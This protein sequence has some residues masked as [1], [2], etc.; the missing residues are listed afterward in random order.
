MN[1]IHLNTED[2]LEHVLASFTPALAAA[3]AKI[4]TSQY[5]TRTWFIQE[6]LLAV[7]LEL[8]FGRHRISWACFDTLVKIL[9]QSMIQ[10][11]RNLI[12]TREAHLVKRSAAARLVSI[13]R[14][15]R[16][17]PDLPVTKHRNETRGLPYW[18]EAFQGAKCSVM[19]DK[20]YGM[21][22]LA[23]GFAF[24]QLFPVDYRKPLV[25]LVIDTLRLCPVDDSVSF[26]KVLLSTLKI[27]RDWLSHLLLRGVPPGLDVG[28]TL[29][30]KRLGQVIQVTRL[31]CV[32]DFAALQGV[33]LEGLGAFLDN[34]ARILCPNNTL[35]VRP[36]NCRRLKTIM[37]ELSKAY[38]NTEPDSSNPPYDTLRIHEIRLNNSEFHAFLTRAPDGPRTDWGLVWGNVRIGD[39][40][41]QIQGSDRTYLA[42]PFYGGSRDQY[43]KCQSTRLRS[44]FDMQAL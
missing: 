18:I 23:R 43:I 4:C 41:C 17:S 6:V 40:L 42:R 10:G 26:L 2:N 16:F 29:K 35:Q 37:T 32:D 12:A 27:Q 5:W 13:R 20:I 8:H 39:T 33:T 25:D 9:E 36:E 44:D 21:L 22:G 31:T 11:S 34:T 30:P 14:P 15:S 38:T 3:V 24:G 1:P 7:R 28:Y 19:H